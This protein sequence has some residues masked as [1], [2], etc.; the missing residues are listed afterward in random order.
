MQSVNARPTIPFF[1]SH[2]SL[3]IALI[4]VILA[5]V[6]LGTYIAFKAT[7]V[8]SPPQAMT[9]LSQQTLAEQYGLGVNLIAVTFAGGM[10]DLRLK[11]IDGEKAKALLDDQTNF[12]ALRAGNGVVL[13]ASEDVAKQEIKFE[14]G[15][16][17]FILYP[18]AQNVFKPGDPVTIVF[19]NIQLEP[20][21]AK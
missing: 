3:L 11:I 13:R 9:V 20:I 10:L 18:N 12:P 5:V 14:N 7:Q 19:G 16:N 2:K 21:P 6:G 8:Q 1:Q 17:L 4:L 15:S